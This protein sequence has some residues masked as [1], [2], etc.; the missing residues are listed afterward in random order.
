MSREA[1]QRLGYWLGIIVAVLTIAAYGKSA[2]DERYLRRSTYRLDVK[3]RDSAYGSDKLR[4]SAW[5][6]TQMEMV[7][8][9]LCSRH[10]DP[11]NQRCRQ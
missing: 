9:I 7:R 4:D 8:D 5:K 10:V 11:R 3:T 2:A 1:K 6:A